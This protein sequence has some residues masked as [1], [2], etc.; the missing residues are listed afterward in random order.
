MNFALW[1]YTNIWLF[2]NVTSNIILIWYNLNHDWGFGCCCVWQQHLC[3]AAW[4][5]VPWSIWCWC[6]CQCWCWCWCRCLGQ[7]VAEHCSPENLLLFSL[8][9][10][11]LMLI[12]ML[13]S[14]ENLL[15]L[16]WLM[17]MPMLILVLY[18]PENWDCSCADKS[19]IN[20]DIPS[21]GIIYSLF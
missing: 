4:M 19:Y 16:L 12:L 18:S 7:F 15:L 10:L 8:Q 1:L 9:L 2:S 11:I 3:N 20:C 13:Y 14:A 6:W 21:A 5:Q 17:L